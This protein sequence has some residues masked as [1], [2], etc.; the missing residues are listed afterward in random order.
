MQFIW[1]FA[2]LI[3]LS[4]CERPK[5]FT[6]KKVLSQY[7][8]D[9]RWEVLSPSS[10][11]QDQLNEIFSRP[12]SYLESGNHCYA[13]VSENDQFVLKFFK[14]K[15]MR[16]QSFIDY[17]PMP[18]KIL[19]YPTKKCMRRK[20]E[21][22]KSFNS[23]KIAYEHLKKE[24]GIFYLHLNKTDH[25]NQMVTLIDQHGDK[26]IVDIDDM[27]FL[28]QRKAEVGYKHLDRLFS[29]GKQ[30]EA[31][32]SIVSLISIIS[33][34]IEKGFFDKDLQFFKNFGF[35]GNQAIEI[36]I[37]ELRPNPVIKNTHAMREELSE[38]SKQLI[39][40]VE[41]HHP[42]YKSEVEGVIEDMLNQI[43]G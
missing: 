42:E 4:G 30:E 16:T 29:E 12:F 20:K 39:S 1:V 7:E 40:W 36:D 6:L 41:S 2:L 28:I 21:R 18:A 22:E 15:H 37:G 5:G 43:R 11:E 35:I 8:N 34:R 31:L 10:Y 25:L 19:F 38:I 17:F 24:T 9:P 27:E 33:H 32:E 26:M 13:F 3:P 14:Q 23:Y